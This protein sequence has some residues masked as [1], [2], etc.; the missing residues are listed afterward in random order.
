MY[1]VNQPPQQGVTRRLARKDNTAVNDCIESYVN[2]IW[3]LARKFTASS[4]EAEAATEEMFAD[5]RRY[6]S[7]ADIVVTADDQ[8]VSL[9]ARRRLFKDLQQH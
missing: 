8:I 4:E 9:I 1:A 6:A 3:A 7:R 5:I 2:F